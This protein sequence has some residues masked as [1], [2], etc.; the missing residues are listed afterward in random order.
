MYDDLSGSPYAT[1]LKLTFFMPVKEPIPLCVPRWDEREAL[2]QGAL[3][4]DT[5]GFYVHAD[6][7]L[8]PVWLW[9]PLRWRESPALIPEMLPPSTWE[10]NLRTLVPPDRWDAIRKHAYAAA[11][12]RCEICGLKGTPHLEAHERWTWDDTWCVQKLE[13]VLA[14]CRACHKALHWGLAKRLGIVEEVS[15]KICE[16]NGWSRAKLAEE[17]ERLKMIMNE[18]SRYHWTVDLSWLETGSYNL[19]YQLG[20]SR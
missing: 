1:Y 13:G 11:G 8:D 15:R 19:I 17:V 5:L 20:G 16:V 12:H 3:Y 9:V 14:L 2:S 7:F 4:S 18:R 10:D 6:A